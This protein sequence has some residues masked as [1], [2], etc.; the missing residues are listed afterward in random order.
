MYF[1]FISYPI[2]AFINWL[3]ITDSIVL[4]NHLSYFFML[5]VPCLIK[6]YTSVFKIKIIFINSSN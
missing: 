4:H 2:H 1:L 3:D 6:K 5:V